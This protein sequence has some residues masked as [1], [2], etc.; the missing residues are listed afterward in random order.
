MKGSGAAGNKRRAALNSPPCTSGSSASRKGIMS[1]ALALLAML[2]E[3]CLGYPRPLLHAIGHPVTWIGRLISALDHRLNHD[4]SEPDR[5]RA[6]GI[7][8]VLLILAIV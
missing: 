4:A 1:V 8:A 3:L 7:I 5:R 6:A 2:I